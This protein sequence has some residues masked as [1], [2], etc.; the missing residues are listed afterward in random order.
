MARQ[1][2]QRD[3]S[4]ILNAASVWIHTCLI[5]D[6]SLFSPDSRWTASLADEVY[7][8]FV[9][10]PD[11]GPEDFITKLKGQMTRSSTAA[12]Q[13]MAEMLWA[14]L[15]FP[16]NMK[17]Y[18]KRPQI[19]EVWALSGQLLP[20]NHPLLVDNVLMGIGPGGMGFA[21]YRFYELEYCIALVRDL[22]RRDPSERRSI[23][24][25]YDAFFEWIESVPRSGNR[26]FRHMLRYFAFPDLVE[27]ISS[28]GDRIAI[29][30]KF[31]A[32]PARAISGWTDRQLDERL[33]RLRREIEG[34]QPG[35]ILDFYEPPLRDRWIPERK[36]RTAG[37]EISIAIPV[38]EEEPEEGDAPQA[39][40]ESTEARQSIRIQAKLARIG[41]LLNF[42]VWLPAADRGRVRELLTDQERAAILDELNLIYE[43]NA[44]DTVK[45]IDVLWIKR[46]SIA[47]AFE[48]EHTTAVYSGLLRMADLLSLQP[49]LDISLH[50]VAPEER[51]E[52]V[53]RELM[54]PVFAFL[55]RGPLSN[56][57]DFISYESIEYI[58][59]LEH[60]AYMNDSILDEYEERAPEAE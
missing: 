44:L 14:L 15:L 13:L 42:K 40:D 4:P 47:H 20:N 52:K 9:E 30:E 10:N 39:A 53:F 27:R 7:R 21:A 46:N 45:Q 33:L 29:L 51:R 31:G 2:S 17:P 59:R 57:C 8:A 60:L 22:K 1:T 48:V 36:I 26:Q 58:N 38:K 3:I 25:D 37:G 23:L 43:R 35:A 19:E 54:R 32:A 50:I 18:T 11:E 49:N 12:I 56:T 28:N 41:V 24:T 16:S 34:G 5:E 6:R 55:E